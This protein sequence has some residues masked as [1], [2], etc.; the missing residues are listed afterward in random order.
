M[1]QEIAFYRKSVCGVGYQKRGTSLPKAVKTKIAN[2][3]THHC[4]LTRILEGFKKRFSLK[5]LYFGNNL[6]QG[7]NL[8]KL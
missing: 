8:S 5:W 6:F 2:I 1:P 4:S 3:Y 7:E